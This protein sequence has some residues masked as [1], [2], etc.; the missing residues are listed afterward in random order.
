MSPEELKEKIQTISIWRR[1]DV[2]A[3]H[4]PLLLIFAIS[5]YLKGHDRLFHFETEIDESLTKLLKRYGPCR[6]NYHSTYP[7][8]RLINDGFWELTNTDNCMPRKSNTDPPKSELINQNVTGGFSKPAHK[9][10]M[11]N[12]S[13]A[14][15]LVS[16]ILKDNF[17]E[18][19]QEDIIETLDFDLYEIIKKRDPAFRKNILRA[20]GYKCAICELDLR[21]DSVTACLDAAHIKWKQYGGPCD[22]NNGICLCTLH[23]RA[24]DK[25]AIGFDKDMK[26]IVSK[27]V[28][29][30]KRVKELFFDFEGVD[31]YLP[32]LKND[33]PSEKYIEWH[34]KEVFH[35]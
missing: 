28:N 34:F 7:F 25:G 6:S 30:N 17:P 5:E 18:S 21:L 9:L 12:P 23:H 22:T 2:R 24:F 27:S 20:Y 13:L 31:C 33:H 15:E 32:R 4:K 10:L 14:R 26:I 35:K 29:G 19:I 16:L 11:V 1:G 8:W 3:P